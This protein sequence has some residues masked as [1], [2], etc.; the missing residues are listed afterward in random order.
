MYIIVDFTVGT[1]ADLVGFEGSLNTSTTFSLKEHKA[2]WKTGGIEYSQIKQYP[3]FSWSNEYNESCRLPQFWNQD[4]TPILADTMPVDQVGCYD[5]EFDHYGDTEA[6]GSHP[7]W[8]REL[9]K[10]A[11]VQDRLREWKPS[12]MAKLK[13]FGCLAIEMLDVDGIRIDKATQMTVDA[14]AE[15]SA[16]THACATELGKTNFFI[17]GEITGGNDF[18]SVYLGRGRAADQIPSTADAYTMNTTNGRYFIRRA[19]HA[20]PR[21]RSV[22]LLDLPLARALPRTRRKPYDRLR[23]PRRLRY[24]VEHNGHQE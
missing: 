24:S 22:P 14:L 9:S 8:Q 17:P 13:V 12:V 11:S 5:S 23:R 6:F 21:R 10:F 18:G 3:D 1:L 20:G 2:V 7:D 4:G 16:A 19:G 15:W